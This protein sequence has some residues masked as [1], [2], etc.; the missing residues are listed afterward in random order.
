MD[1]TKSNETDTC[2]IKCTMNIYC[3]SRGKLTKNM[4]LTALDLYTR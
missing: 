1:K 4:E 3:Q 2:Y